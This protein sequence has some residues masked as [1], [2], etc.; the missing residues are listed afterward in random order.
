VLFTEPTFLFGFLPLLLCLYYAAP[1]RVRNL[2]LVMASVVFYARD[3]GAF[4]WIILGSIVVNGTAALW[5]E[6][7]R[8]TPAATVLLRAIIA[9]NLLSL[10]VFKY[11]G[12]VI[13]N[14]NLGLQTTGAPPLT[15][16]SM[17]SAS[18]SSPSNRSPTSSTSTT[19]GGAPLPLVDTA[20]CSSRSSR[21]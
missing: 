20:L 17:L 13:D 1:W 5:V 12:F 21:S 4:T 15:P 8:G 6:R 2:L 14:L 19:R 10:I 9:L 3:G 18:R 16:P 11:A 7:L